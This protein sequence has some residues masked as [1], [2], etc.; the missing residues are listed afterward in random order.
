MTKD[1][2]TK[3]YEFY[4]DATRDTQWF[5]VREGLRNLGLG[6][7]VIISGKPVFRLTEAGN[8]LRAVKSVLE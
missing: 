6:E 8:R 3:L 4:R 2:V 5:D 1:D 7:W